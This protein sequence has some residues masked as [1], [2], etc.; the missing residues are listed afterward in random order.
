M[1]YQAQGAIK[2]RTVG[3]GGTNQSENFNVWQSVAKCIHCGTAMHLVNKGKKPKGGTYLQC[4]R[5]RKGLCEGKLFRLDHSEHVFRAM[6][7]RLDSRTLVDRGAAEALK[8]LAQVDGRLFEQRA[9]LARYEEDY[10][11]APSRALAVLMG[12]AESAAQQLEAEKEV[13]QASLSSERSATSGYDAFM[14]QLDLASVE[15]RQRANTLLLRLGVLAHVGAQGYIVSVKGRVAFGLAYK[16]GQ[17]GYFASAATFVS[18][19]R[20]LHIMATR[21]LKTMTLMR[22]FI[23]ATDA[24]LSAYAAKVNAEEEANS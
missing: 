20:E 10:A 11:V 24:G 2:A 8:T 23:P 9:M 19:E 12:R 16:D 6:L 5:A 21:A 22:E 4:H 7:A 13:L 18:K 17:A 3:G 1:F 14:K 15:G